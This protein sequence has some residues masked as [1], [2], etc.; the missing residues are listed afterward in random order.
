MFVAQSCLTLCKSMDCSLP[1][2]SVHGI[3]QARILQWV[4][5]PFSRESSWPTDWTWI[6]CT[7][8]RFFTIWATREAPNWQYIPI[9]QQ[10]HFPCLSLWQLPYYWVSQKSPLGFSIRHGKSQTNIFF[11]QFNISV[12]MNLTV[13][14]ISY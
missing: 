14:G 12:S 6:S 1:G 11:G 2:S 3:L 4:F 10:L 5:I 9:K 8:G 7:A 13:L